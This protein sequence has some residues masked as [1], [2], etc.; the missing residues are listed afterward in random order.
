M[1]ATIYYFSSTGNS[2]HMARAIGKQFGECRLV[3][4]A[5]PIGETVVEDNSDTVGIVFPVFYWNVPVLVQEYLKKIKLNS[6]AYTFAV[7]TCGGSAGLTLRTIDT[8]LREKGGHLSAGFQLIMPDNAYIGINLVTPLEKR[9]QM[10]KAAEGELGKILEV[11]GKR[12]TV[13]LKGI[14]PIVGR[15]GGSMTGMFA[16]QIYGLPKRFHATDKCNGC[17]TCVRV[18]PADNVKQ[19]DKKVTWGNNCTH[20]LACFHWCPKQAVEIGKKSGGIARYHHPAIKVK[21]IMLK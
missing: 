12:E 9:E 6:K 15:I 17:G 1:T 7:A 3:N 20:C 21:D 14:S 5:K 8:I 10:L 19:A 11:L 2:L 16:S 4:M 13:E 18:C